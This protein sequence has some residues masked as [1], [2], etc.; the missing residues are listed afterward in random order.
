MI[1][2][3]GALADFLHLI[4][5]VADE[6]DCGS[7]FHQLF[8]SCL[9]LLLELV[10]A[11][12]EDLVHHQ[13]VR[14]DLRGDGKAQPG[15]HTGGIVLDRHVDELPQLGKVH[16]FLEICVHK[17]PVVAHDGAV[18]INILP[19]GQV[20]VKA[21]AQFNQGGNGAIDPDPSLACAQD[22][23]NDFQHGAL[24]AAVPT[25]QRHGFSPLNGKGHIFERIE[26]GKMEL[27]LQQLHKILLDGIRFLLRQIEAHGDIVNRDNLA[28]SFPRLQIQDE[29]FLQL[30]E[31]GE[32]DHQRKNAGHRAAD[33]E[34]GPRN[35]AVHDHLTEEGQV[36]IHGV[37]FD[38]RHGKGRQE[39]RV[40]GVENGSQVGQRQCDHTVNIGDIPEE[41]RNGGQK[42]SASDAEQEQQNQRNPEQQDGPVQ[43]H[44]GKG[45]DDDDR[46]QTEG[47]VR[48]GGQ[49]PGHGE[50]VL[51][52][53]DLP[54]QAA[55][56]ENGG[57]GLIGA[58]VEEGKQGVAGNQVYIKIRNVGLEHEGKDNGHD[59]HHQH[60][61]QQTP[62][63]AEEASA[64]LHLQVPADQFLEQGGVFQKVLDFCFHAG[65]VSLRYSIF[66]W[67]SSAAHMP[68]RRV[69]RRFPFLVG[70][71]TRMAAKSRAQR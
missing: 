18:H 60:G 22:S 41:G 39:L 64:V 3:D 52:Y 19:G 28:H 40:Y 46:C 30:A 34:L 51:G 56:C 63:V 29:V 49:D 14:A 8:H 61:V 48:K 4:I 47:Q 50:N 59:H 31:H 37:H 55:V 54:D 16:D 17:L 13:N 2:P 6:Q 43:R 9:A 21:R 70:A 33:P 66:G 23:G 38:D 24:A 11:H 26:L 62:H 32:A 36:I 5:T 53:I 1:Q 57:H 67:N 68:R 7:A 69:R 10:V 12:G 44:P 15:D 27:M 42:Q 45:H 65:S 20:H 25:D 71:F 35:S 58:L